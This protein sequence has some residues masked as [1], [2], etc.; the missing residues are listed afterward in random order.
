MLAA[1]TAAPAGAG[2][3]GG[4]SEPDRPGAGTRLPRIEVLGWL[5]YSRQSFRVLMDMLAERSAR[6]QRTPTPPSGPPSRIA[7]PPD[8]DDW[9]APPP[10]RRSPPMG[11]PPGPPMGPPMGPPTGPPPDAD[12]AP[13]ERWQQPHRPRTGGEAAAGPNRTPAVQANMWREP[14]GGHWDAHRGA[15]RGA[16]CRKAGVEVDG[17]GWYVVR[18]GDTLWSIAEMHYGNGE[19]Y[20]R[21]LRA[22][23][24]RI[25]DADHLQPCQRLYIPRWG[26]P[27][28]PQEDDWRDRRRPCPAD[29]PGDRAWPPSCEGSRGGDA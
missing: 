18:A 5:R 27:R 24:Q 12:D 25:A 22:N 8:A 13:E 19:A 26:A 6:L 4:T 15:H 2:R 9:V 21:I 11:P 17:A 1:L 10:R 28:P 23:W 20:R 29:R 16:R 14:R 7:A 3:D